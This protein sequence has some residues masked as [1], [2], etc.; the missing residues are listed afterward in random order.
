[1]AGWS[2]DGIVVGVAYAVARREIVASYFRRGHHVTSRNLLAKR[3]HFQ[4]V[5]PVNYFPAVPKKHIISI[6][7]ESYF[8]QQHTHSQI[9]T[10]HCRVLAPGE[11]STL[12]LPKECFNEGL[13]QLI[14]ERS[15]DKSFIGQ[16]IP[17]RHTDP[18]IVRQVELIVPKPD[19][20]LRDPGGCGDTDLGPSV[21]A[22]L[23]QRDVVF[24]I[25]STSISRNISS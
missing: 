22:K 8:R 1:M 4:M 15:Q 20:Y 7:L 10:A 2:R 24:Q 12:S 6:H 17:T 18:D 25:I 16:P 3:L 5:V 9:V 14:V 11:G 23:A 13:C 19:Q 21:A